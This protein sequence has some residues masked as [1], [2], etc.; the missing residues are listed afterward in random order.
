MWAFVYLTLNTLIKIIDEVIDWPQQRYT[1]P[2]SVGN[3]RLAAFE[4][5]FIDIIPMIT[6]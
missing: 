4:T 2:G 1:P 5:I 3:N 6:R